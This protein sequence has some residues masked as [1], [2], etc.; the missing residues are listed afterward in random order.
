LPELPADLESTPT[1]P[2]RSA[3]V[4]SRKGLGSSMGT[5]NPSS[6]AKFFF[7]TASTPDLGS[8]LPTSLSSSSSSSSWIGGTEGGDGGES[9]SMS[10]LES[11]DGRAGL[12]ACLRWEFTKGRG[13]RGEG[14]VRERGKAGGG[15]AARGIVSKLGAAEDVG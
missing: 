13:V 14:K 9:A 11:G 6:R 15:A 12:Y 3:P 5:S 8:G 1:F 4:R 2:F 10:I 7:D